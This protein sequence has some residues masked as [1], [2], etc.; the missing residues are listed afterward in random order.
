MKRFFWIVLS[1]LGPA[2]YELTY[3]YFHGCNH[4]LSVED[5]FFMTLVKLRQHKTNFEMSRMFDVSEATIT[6]IFVTWVNFIACHQGEIDW[7]PS[8]DLV[9]LYSP[10]D[11][12]QKFPSTRV[13][14]DGTECPIKNPKEPIAQQA[15]FSTYIYKYRMK[16]VGSMISRRWRWDRN[17][18]SPDMP[19]EQTFEWLRKTLTNHY[20]P[21][22][23]IIAKR[24]RFNKR[25]QGDNES[26][27]DYMVALKQLAASGEFGALLNEALRDRFV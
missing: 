8:R 10:T 13:I 22:R 11:C 25:N 21:Q 18:L 7:W 24:F 26:V 3:I 14:A 19:S 4:S 20:K 9:R 27:A 6:N 23:V 12:K 17:L 15:T 5:Q 16:Q 1:T 2:A